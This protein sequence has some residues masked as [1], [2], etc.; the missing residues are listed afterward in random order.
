VKF[1]STPRPLDGRDV[2]SRPLIGREAP[3]FRIVLNPHP[4]S[5][6]NFFNLFLKNSILSTRGQVMARLAHVTGKKI[7]KCKQSLHTSQARERSPTRTDLSKAKQRRVTSASPP[8]LLSACPLPWPWRWR[9]PGSS[10]STRLRHG[11]PAAS[12]ALR[13]SSRS[14][15]A[16]MGNP[17][18]PTLSALVDSVITLVS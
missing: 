1:F 9:L 17:T 14:A 15:R 6:F 5:N 13:S 18:S 7:L 10:T 8:L 11:A 4:F 16:P 2:S 3:I 12:T